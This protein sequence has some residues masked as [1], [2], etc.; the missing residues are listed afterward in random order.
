M[1][2]LNRYRIKG[3]TYF[4]TLALQDWNSEALSNPVQSLCKELV[5][6]KLRYAFTIDA[7]VILPKYLQGILT[8]PE[9]AGDLALL[10]RQIISEFSILAGADENSDLAD[11][12]V[13]WRHEDEASAEQKRFF[14]YLIRDE[15]DFWEHIHYLHFNPVNQG[16]VKLV[17]DW[18]YSTFFPYVKQGVYSLSWE[19]KS[20]FSL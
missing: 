11:L 10:W 4:F 12:N 8:L 19:G 9:G 16:L 2:E 1:S 17:S 14:G 15:I 20:Q 13:G 5:K 7:L 3:E 18:P 6:I